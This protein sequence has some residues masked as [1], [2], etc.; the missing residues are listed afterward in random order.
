MKKNIIAALIILLSLFLVSCSPS[1]ASNET[2]SPDAF[3]QS[4]SPIPGDK[5]VASVVNGVDDDTAYKLSS[6]GFSDV[7]PIRLEGDRIICSVKL[8]SENALPY[9]VFLFVNGIPQSFQENGAEQTS[10]FFNSDL[11]QTPSVYHNF[12]IS[13]VI[14]TDDS[15]IYLQNAV[16]AN[17]KHH[18]SSQSLP[19][20]SLIMGLS[21]NIASTTMIKAEN[22]PMN[23]KTMETGQSELLPI[24]ASMREILNIPED[25]NHAA[26]RLLIR[27]GNG[28]GFVRSPFTTREDLQN[29][30]DVYAYG[31]SAG[32][33]RISFFVN[34]EPQRDPSG[35]PLVFDMA[36]EQNM[37]AHLNLGADTIPWVNDLQTDDVFFAIAAPSEAMS[38]DVIFKSETTVL[39]EK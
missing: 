2:I 39:R 3:S 28:D 11:I 8:E 38:N 13:P 12:S 27:T 33:Y 22:P 4:A 1:P 5:P 29:G 32:K 19:G 36:L 7:D 9:A 24:D 6:F 16:I 37:V 23:Y 30:L 26:N 10:P 20:E 21:Q 34:F 15:D 25:L 17:P 14:D 35:N 18:P 31:G